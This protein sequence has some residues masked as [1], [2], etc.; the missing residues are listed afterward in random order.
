MSAAAERGKLAA[1][2]R[3]LELVES[4]TTLG[5]GTG[6]TADHFTRLLGARVAEGLKLCCVATS[7]RTASLARSLKIPLK[8]LDEVERIDLTVDGADELDRELRLIKG[9]GGA[10]LREKLVAS[11]SRRM[12]VIADRSKLVARLGA[13]PLP[14]EIVRFGH[15]TTARRLEEGLG[16]FITGA[17]Q[18]KLRL[19][20]TTAPFVSD[21]GN[22]I[23]DLPC[24]QIA[25]PDGLARYLD[26]VV[27]VV[28]H[29][30]FLGMATTALVGDEQGQVEVIEAARKR[31]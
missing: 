20:A 26:G 6:S 23:F 8:E 30:L 16:Q 21:G 3:A 19:A 13:F 28:E 10:L 29:G 31:G 25:D 27:G 11:A 22:R 4:G 15:A 9:G 1:A 14:V 12:V 5:L 17:A 7:E 18:A 24:G 2:A